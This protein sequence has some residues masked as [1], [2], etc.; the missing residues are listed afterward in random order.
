MLNNLPN[1]LEETIE[2]DK[3]NSDLQTR[4]DDNDHIMDSVIKISTALC[5][6]DY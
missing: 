5:S 6:S 1:I 4:P 3:K 2:E